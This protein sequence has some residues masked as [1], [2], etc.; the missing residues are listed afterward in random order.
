MP[1]RI[2]CVHVFLR[3]NPK[4]IYSSINVKYPIIALQLD[5]AYGIILIFRKTWYE[6]GWPSIHP[7]DGCINNVSNIP[8]KISGIIKCT[9]EFNDLVIKA[10]CYVTDESFN[11]FGFG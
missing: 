5:T 7:T 6:L 2:N 10:K 9:A 1:K 3:C 4:R 8:I 11:L